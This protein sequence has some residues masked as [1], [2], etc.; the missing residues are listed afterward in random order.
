MFENAIKDLSHKSFPG[1]LP[2]E[3]GPEIGNRQS[4]IQSKAR[5]P[6]VVAPRPRRLIKTCE[7][8]N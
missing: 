1:L 8:L 3:S 6:P 5:V 2:A 4:E 7:Q